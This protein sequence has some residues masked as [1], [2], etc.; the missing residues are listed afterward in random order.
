MYEL[1]DALDLSAIDKEVLAFWKEQDIF[2]KS[3]EQRDPDHT[4]V[5]MKGPH[6]P[7]V[8]LVSIT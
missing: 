6:R 5:F 1:F 8:C 2:N 3:I 7:M 4:Y